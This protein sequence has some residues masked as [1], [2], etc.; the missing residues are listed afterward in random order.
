MEVERVDLK[1]MV[2]L[3]RL[4]SN[5]LLRGS[6]SSVLSFGMT[7]HNLGILRNPKSYLPY[8]PQVFGEEK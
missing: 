3:L 2:K 4:M 7:T 6:L 8:A 1:I 5:P